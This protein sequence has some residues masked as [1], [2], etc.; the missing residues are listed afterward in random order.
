[1]YDREETKAGKV[2]GKEEGIRHDET[3]T[4]ET[5]SER[6]LWRA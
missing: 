1:M 3:I 5:K 4:M 2:V 6:I